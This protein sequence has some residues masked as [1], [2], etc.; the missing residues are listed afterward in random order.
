MLL[1][2]YLSLFGAIIWLLRGEHDDWV[3]R[4]RPAVVASIR[5]ATSLIAVLLQVVGA[6]VLVKAS[7]LDALLITLAAA[8]IGGGF[9]YFQGVALWR[10]RGAYSLRVVGWCLVVAA[11]SVPSILTLALPVVAIM[12]VVL[13]QVP[14]AGS[15]RSPSMLR[16]RAPSRARSRGNMNPS[17]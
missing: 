1:I 4:F 7:E 10:G 9:L 17:S 15:P 5:I 2:A 8:L 14:V 3:D 13:V 12:A 16:R 11:L 6:L